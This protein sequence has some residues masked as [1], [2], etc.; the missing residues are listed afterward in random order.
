MGSG[1]GSSTHKLCDQSKLL[2]LTQNPCLYFGNG[3]DMT[4]FVCPRP[5]EILLYYVGLF[6]GTC[7][8]RE[9]APRLKTHHCKCRARKDRGKR[10]VTPVW[11]L[12]EFMKGHL[13]TRCIFSDCRT[14]WI[15]CLP[16][17][18]HQRTIQG[19][20]WAIVTGTSM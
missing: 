9:K 2:T 15:S 10:Q 13:H 7:G 18:R 8:P 12:I 1:L 16:L 5:V 17:G 6:V 3:I 19:K 14:K 20:R 4:F 11:Q